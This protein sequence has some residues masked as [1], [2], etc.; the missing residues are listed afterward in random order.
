MQDEIF[1]ADIATLQARMADG[2]AT[3][4]SLL[5][6]CLARIRAYDQDGPKL[7]SVVCLAPG[8]LEE[9]RALD[10]ER[11]RHGPRGPLHGIPLLVKDNYDSADMPTSAGA[12][13][14]ATHQP[15]QD[16]WALGRLREA[17]AVIVGKTTLHELA[18]GITNTS[19]LTGST[20]NPYDPRRVPGGSSGG[21]AAAIAA[22]FATAGLGSD[23]SGSLRIPAAVNNLVSLRATPGLIGRSGI[24]PLSPTQDCAGPLARSVHDLALLL[25]ALAGADPQDPASRMGG[26]GFHARLNPEGLKGLRIGVIGEL[27]G[28]DADEEEISRRCREALDAMRDLGADVVEIQIPQLTERLRASSL[29]PLEF[30]TALAAYLARH[31]QTPIHSLGGILKRGLHHQALDAVLRLRNATEDSNGSR[32]AA[33]LLLRQALR[34]SVQQAMHGLDVLA[35]PSLRRRPAMI[36]EPQGGANAQLSPGIG[37]PALCLPAGFTSD[38]LPLGLELLGRPGSDQAL[39]DAALHWERASQPRRAPF[40]T[41]QLLRLPASRRRTLH[42]AP[43]DPADIAVTLHYEADLPRAELRFQAQAEGRDSD[44]LIALTLHSPLG[45]VIAPLLRASLSAEGVLPLQGDWAQA[46]LG[47]G[48]IVRLYTQRHPL[49]VDCGRVHTG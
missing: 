2:S 34:D 26:G 14:L 40:T 21:T 49:G 32:L 45:P 9:A 3:A 30:R 20:R 29:T 37:F 36:G 33:T 16:A 12:L 41:P 1:E 27:F 15:T 4:E 8:A 22:S 48:L 6:A 10:Q 31:P 7:N 47:P 42:H 35:Y 46:L 39:L 24:V 17:G 19:S 44:A 23:T 38:A 28:S 11:A 5:L 18:A 25:D 43:A 13:A